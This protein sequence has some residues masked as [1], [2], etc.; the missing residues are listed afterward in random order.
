MEIWVVGW[1]I[2]AVV[3]AIIG[4]NK[5]RPAA[6]AIYG[7]L[8][9]PLGWIV[10]L[11][12]PDVRP[13]C[14]ECG[15]TTVRGAQKCMNCGSHLR[16]DVARASPMRK[17]GAMARDR[18]QEALSG[19]SSASPVP[20]LPPQRL[21]ESDEEFFESLGIESETQDGPEGQMPGPNR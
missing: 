15:G 5:G 6:G 20:D 9:G 17:P 4:N 8:L 19:R 1:L 12:A 3:G 2:S 10:I 11:I 16:P 14:P 18:D 21:P 7:L 13:K